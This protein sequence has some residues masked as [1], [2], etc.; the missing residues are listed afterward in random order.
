MRPLIPANIRIREAY[1]DEDLTTYI[2][3]GQMHQVI[4][5][6]LTNAYQA[7]PEKGG[8]ID[9]ITDKVLLENNRDQYIGLGCGRYVRLRIRDTGEGISQEHLEQ[10]FDPYFTTKEMG[11]GTGLGLS[12]VQGV[13][14]EGQGEVF[15]NSTPGKGST[16][17][18]LLP[19]GESAA[20]DDISDKS[21]FQGQEQILFVDDEKP[22]A[23]AGR[24]LLEKLGY[25]AWGI[26]DAKEA[27]DLFLRDPQKFD[28]II[29]DMA[30]PGMTGPD[31]AREM[32]KLRPE[33]PII[34]CTGHH[35]K[36]DAARAKA[37]GFKAFLLKPVKVVEL[38]TAVRK[39]F[40]EK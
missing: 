5:N 22:L 16:V 4:I 35:D 3:P 19:V 37:M 40:D 13:I 14:H 6:L 32:F 25:A 36:M 21:P 31:L 15:I 26:S 12:V 20:D 33:I 34:L 38:T 11:T 23:K 17:E 1:T 9:V 8:T 28:L 10:V 7:I 18:V 2:D 27:L 24:D 39:V 29:T 30:M